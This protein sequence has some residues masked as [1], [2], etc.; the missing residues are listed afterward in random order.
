MSERVSKA[1]QRLVVERAGGC[2]EYCGM[3]D[4]V[5][6]LPH[7]PDYII[8]TQHGGQT[9]LD[10]LAYTCFRCNRFKGPNLASID[11]QTSAIAPLFNPRTD[12]WHVHFR[13]E[14]AEMVPLTAVG[15]A[16]IAL[17]RCGDAERVALRA[18]LIRQGRYPFLAR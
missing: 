5:M 12:D 3:P 16:T 2:C 9:T 15:R 17:L 6:R 8:A 13:W 11:P 4:D 7:E 1:L 14:Q 18:N 10:N